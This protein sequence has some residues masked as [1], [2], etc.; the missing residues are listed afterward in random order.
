MRLQFRRRQLSWLD[1]TPGAVWKW[2]ALHIVSEDV[3]E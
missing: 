1:V 2:T 3:D